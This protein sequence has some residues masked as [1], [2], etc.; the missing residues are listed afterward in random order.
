MKGQISNLTGFAYILMMVGIVVAV[1]LVVLS[2]FQTVGTPVQTTT[3]ANTTNV[4]NPIAY[5]AQVNVYIT[6]DQ[7]ASYGEFRQGLLTYTST[8]SSATIPAEN[9][10]TKLNGVVFGRTNGYNT[11]ANWAY[12]LTA[13]QMLNGKNNVSFI[14]GNTTNISSVTIQF[15]YTR[16]QDLVARN[17]VGSTMDAFTTLIGWLPVIVVII[18]V[19][20]VLG[21][22]GMGFSTAG[23]KSKR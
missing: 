4:N 16:S 13:S 3:V 9:F 12:P 19:A 15:N 2:Q 22:L 10:T 8:N 21:L 7:S 6:F 1:G 23:K 11:S 17:T 14:L 5:G 18:A 20:I